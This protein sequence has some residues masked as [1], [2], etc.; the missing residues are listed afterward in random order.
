MLKTSFARRSRRLAGRA[1]V[2]LACAAA[3]TVLAPTGGA[4]TPIKDPATIA[5]PGAPSGWA[6][7]PVIKSLA[8]PQSVPEPAAEEH[9]ATGGN[10]VIVSCTYAAS[11]VKQITVAVSYTLPTDLNPNDD[12]YWGCGTGANAW[13][14][15]DRVF[16]VASID[17]WANADFAD[18]ADS[19][20]AADVPVFQS[21]ARQLLQ[22]AEGYAHPCSLVSKPTALTTRYL[23]DIPV[24]GGNIKSV[25][26][27][28]GVPEKGV[29]VVP[30]VSATS[31]KVSLKVKAKGKTS[32]LTIA[33][34]RGLDYRQVTAHLVGRA[35][36]A[37]QVVGSKVPSCHTGAK[38]TLTI[39]TAPS[40]LLSVCGQ[41][42]LR[43]ER[44]GRVRFIA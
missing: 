4:A 39:T 12:F 5:C 31:S 10:L 41:T 34:T 30:I 18:F 17:Q 8:T 44:L 21:V 20:G 13:N 35:R 14:D 36:F 25:F 19:L 7:Q 33:L 22:N 16:R 29:H 38:G 3:S 9:L 28:K 23:L 32:P 43:G 37:V 2:A 6:S 26:W 1:L 24:A 11:P 40:V 42:F 27:T 15:T